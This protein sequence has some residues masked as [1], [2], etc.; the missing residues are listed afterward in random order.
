MN[1]FILLVLFI[2]RSFGDLIGYN[3]GQNNVNLHNLYRHRMT[4]RYANYDKKQRSEKKQ[5][6]EMYKLLV[7]YLSE[8]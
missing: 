3:R 6:S 4:R 8:P 2:G 1:Y 7:K 5:H